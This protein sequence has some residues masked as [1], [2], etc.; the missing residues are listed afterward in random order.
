[1]QR[2]SI[3]VGE[4]FGLLTV[5]EEVVKLVGGRRRVHFRC[6]CD[7]GTQLEIE[8]YKLR[9]RSTDTSC[10]CARVGPRT[11]HGKSNT[12]E[13]NIWVKMR[14]RCLN[15]NVSDY[16]NYGGR[17]ISICSRWNTF[18]AFIADMG[19]RPDTDFTLDRIDVNG[20][21]S[22]ENCR[23]ANWNTQ[24]RNRRNNRLVVY[25]GRTVTM[26]EA[27]EISG[28]TRATVAIRLTRAK[29]TIAEALGPG[30]SWPDGINPYTGLPDG[31]LHNS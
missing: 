12:P 26:A 16:D 9:N 21:Y 10:G 19:P 18:E 4:K 27:V 22:P 14:Q 17:G 3:P 1:M 30:F 5:T 11:T 31:P 6:L 15:P 7:C 8:T 25:Q 13:F 29:R 24:Q 2:I 28:R 20:N 23:W